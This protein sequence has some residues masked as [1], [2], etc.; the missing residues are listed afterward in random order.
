VP[1]EGHVLTQFDGYEEFY[2][3]NVAASLF[4]RTTTLVTLTNGRAIT[5]WMY[6]YNRAIGGAK[7]IPSGKYV[8]DKSVSPC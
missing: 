3:D 7:L 4:V 1:S 8:A 2:P 5:C 6:V